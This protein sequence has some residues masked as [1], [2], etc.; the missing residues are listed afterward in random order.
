MTTKMY[1][2]IVIGAG[3]AGLSAAAKLREE[4]VHDILVLE[5]Q[6]YIGGRVKTATDWNAPIALG[7]E[8]IHGD[9][10]VTADIARKLGLEML[11]ASG[12]RKLVDENGKVLNSSQEESYYKILDHLSEKGIAGVPIAR[13]I[14]ENPYSQDET[15]KRLVHYTIGDYE[16]SDTIELDSG[17][18][19]EMVNASQKNGE[20]VIL[21]D[22]YPPIVEYL[23]SELEI[24]TGCP[25]KR[26]A[27]DSDS[28]SIELQDGS[29]LAAKHVIITVSL[30]V[31]K[32]R[33]IQFVPELPNEKLRAIE[34][35][36]MGNAIKL[37]LRFNDPFDVHSLFDIADGENV[38]LQTM[39]CW[40]SSANS[41][42]VLVGYC[43]GRRA[44]NVLAMP[45]NELLEKVMSDLG[46][47]L[48]HDVS[49]QLVNYKLV[50]WDTNP[51]TLGAY[52]N[53]PLG[54][55]SADNAVLAR[56]DGRFFWAGE[57]TDMNGDYATVH[58]A[59]ISG[60]RAANEVI[61]ARKQ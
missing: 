48:G 13:L 50:R 1:D 2:V 10:T 28:V 7:A 18:F 20:N 22:S 36:G 41:P 45:E 44:E 53:H 16:A 51:F 3:M 29:I 60:Y 32:S 25:V 40:W 34:L 6:D 19:S 4:G 27:Q 54:S 55:S 47:I 59:I 9:K 37:I 5:A 31:L 33:A 26:I 24:R 8:F 35:L 15:V 14:E 42:H 17:A 39:T 21:K 52:T 56:P 30:G 38:T 12:I 49:K 11:P 58:G 43:G 61:V 46:D 57:A 23:S